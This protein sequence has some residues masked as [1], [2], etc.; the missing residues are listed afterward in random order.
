M[1]RRIVISTLDPEPVGWDLPVAEQHERTDIAGGIRTLHE[2]AVAAAATGREVEL[3]GPVSSLVFDDLTAAAG[4]RPLLPTT[5]RRPT[6]HDIVVVPNGGYDLLRLARSV[7]SPARLVLALLSPTGQSGWP[8]VSPWHQQSHL[9]VSLDSLCRPEHFRAMAAFGIDLW[10]NMKSVPELARS[11]GAHCAFIGNGEP[12]PSPPVR[13]VKSIPVVY[14]EAN[15]WRPLAEKVAGELKTPAHMI[16][17]GDY[18]TVMSALAQ[19]RIMLWPARVEGDGRLLREARMRGTVVVGLASN[20]YATGLEEAG[21]AIAVDSLERMPAA[22]EAL[23][24]APERLEELAEAGRRSAREQVDWAGYVARVDT[25]ITS[26]EQLSEDP[27]A[28]ARGAFGK[29]LAPL[30]EERVRAI[31]RVQELDEHLAVA[32]ARVECLDEELDAARERISQLERR[33]PAVRPP[34]VSRLAQRA[35]STVSAATLARRTRR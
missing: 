7:L 22:V 25:A 34:I 26:T 32:H 20:V 1:S 24:S 14:L 11:A 9:T 30:L 2:L 8:F 15:R 3:R 31:A 29:R 21:G 13:V 6:A 28:S 33:T 23:L 5:A 19:A 12:A 35:R 27:A 16:P 4:A 10:T 17:A 18:E